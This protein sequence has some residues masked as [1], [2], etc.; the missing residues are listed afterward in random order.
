VAA[1]VRR[2][3]RVP[4]PDCA[5]E[6]WDYCHLGR[7]RLSGWYNRETVAATGDRL[8]F[9]PVDGDAVR[10]ERKKVVMA[11][12]RGGKLLRGDLVLGALL[13]EPTP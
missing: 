10:L 11:G 3:E 5:H 1:I 6:E 12:F 8:G 2:P 4:C 7:I 13:A 9:H